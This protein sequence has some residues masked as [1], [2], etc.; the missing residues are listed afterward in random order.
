MVKTTS[1]DI[2]ALDTATAC[3]K[4]AEIEIKNNEGAGVGLFFRILGK[5]SQVFRDHVKQDVNAR[6]RQEALAQRRGK[7][8]PPPTAEEAEEK[9]TEL[10]VLCTLGW[11]QDKGDGTFKDTITYNG[12]ELPFTVANAQ[13]IYTSILPIRR[14]IDQAIGELENFM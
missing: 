9:A 7:D 1:F 13:K 10:L 6:I 5:D 4:G 11:R 8:M 2:S 3:D 14:Q 12:E